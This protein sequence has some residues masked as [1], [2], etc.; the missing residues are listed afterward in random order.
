MPKQNFVIYTK[1]TRPVKSLAGVY[2]PEAPSPPMTPYPPPLTRCIVYTYSHREVGGGWGLGDL[3]Q[4]EVPLQ[5][6]Y[7]DDDVLLWCLYS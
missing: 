5:V 7:L 2:L 4:R 6:I 3:N 1:Y